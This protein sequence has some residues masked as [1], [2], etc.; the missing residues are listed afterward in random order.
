MT[1]RCGL[2]EDLHLLILVIASQEEFSRRGFADLLVQI[3]KLGSARE[4]LSDVC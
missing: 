4:F 2:G 3:R 1:T